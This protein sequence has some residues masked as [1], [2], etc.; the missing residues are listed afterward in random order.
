MYEYF[1]LCIFTYFV[2]RKVPITI[3][4]RPS[5]DF[6]FNSTHPQPKRLKYNITFFLEGN[7]VK[8]GLAFEYRPNP[9]V[10]NIT[11]RKTFARLVKSSLI[12]GFHL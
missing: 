5:F 9:E 4:S 10:L 6:G 11:Q 1:L 2:E 7:D 12:I 3:K 8:T